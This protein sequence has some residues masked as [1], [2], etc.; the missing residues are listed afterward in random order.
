MKNG[1]KFI[2]LAHRV[3]ICQN[4]NCFSNTMGRLKFAICDISDYLRENFYDKI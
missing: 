3:E 2:I 1:Q 4:I